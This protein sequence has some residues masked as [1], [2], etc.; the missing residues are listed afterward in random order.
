MSN[1]ARTITSVDATDLVEV[2]EP[3]GIPYRTKFIT[4]ENFRHTPVAVTATSSGA[5]IPANATH[6]TVTSD[7]ADKIVILPAPV[8]GKRII[9]I[10]G[11]TGYELRSS[12]PTTIGINGG[13][14]ADAESAIGA[15]TVLELICAS[16]TNWIG[17]SYTAAGVKGVVQVAA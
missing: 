10:N 9:I 8:L 5:E 12:S 3:D 14:G 13:T 11:A 7:N 1:S 17:N 6:V 4:V 2:R 16:A 15:S